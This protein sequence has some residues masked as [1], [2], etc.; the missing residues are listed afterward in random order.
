MAPA[1]D[2]SLM[3]VR[4]RL[5]GGIL[6]FIFVSP[7]WLGGTSAAAGQE[8]PSNAHRSTIGRGW[9]CDRGY[10]RTGNEC[11]PVIV[12]PNASLDYYGHG[13][14]C[15]RGFARV[16]NECATVMVPANAKLDYY[17]HG[18]EWNRGYV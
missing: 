6:T 8:V 3:K 18:R 10:A 1:T 4:V 14:E 13:W 9:E 17:G 16:G 12:P 5:I 2:G 15:K 7:F 11:R